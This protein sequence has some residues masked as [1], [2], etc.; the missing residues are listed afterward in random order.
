MAMF[1]YCRGFMDSWSEAGGLLERSFQ[2]G[3]SWLL[4][5]AVDDVLGS[6]VG[7]EISGR[8]G[9]ICCIVLGRC[10]YEGDELWA[11]GQTGCSGCEAEG[12]GGAQAAS[13][14]WGQGRF[15]AENAVDTANEIRLARR[16]GDTECAK[17]EREGAAVQAT[18]GQVGE[19]NG[20]GARGSGTA[21]D[22]VVAG[23]FAFEAET[24]LDPDEDR[25]EGKEDE[26]ELLE[27]VEP[28]VTAAEM[29]DLV[30]DDLVELRAGEL[31]EDACWDEDARGKEADYAW[32]VDFSRGT[33]CGGSTA[34]G[35]ERGAGCGRHGG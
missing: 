23:K 34:I 17:G 35:E 21:E 16:A 5:F 29:L 6:D 2:E 27:E 15:A 28:V 30:Q 31:F 25:V 14:E 13:G 22:A 11:V 3:G 9:A 10:G 18:F 7:I 20:V 4:G 8:E 19:A 24:A 1:A 33:E 12:D 32:P 26:A